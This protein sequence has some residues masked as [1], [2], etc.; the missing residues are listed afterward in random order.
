MFSP[1]PRVRIRNTC[2]RSS[3]RAFSVRGSQ[4]SSLRSGGGVAK[5]CAAA[6]S[7]PR[8]RRFIDCDSLEP[9]PMRGDRH[10]DYGDLWTSVSLRCRYACG[11]NT[12]SR[13]TASTRCGESR[14]NAD[15]RRAGQAL[16]PAPGQPSLWD[17]G[18]TC[19]FLL[20]EDVARADA[21]L[22]RA[23][24]GGHDRAEL[25]DCHGP[26]VCVESSTSRTLRPRFS[27]LIGFCRKARPGSRAPW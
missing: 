7:T 16:C 3:S 13:Q 15:L 23:K 25:A 6:P 26:Y 27:G 12:C 18:R 19:G 9:A 22:Y 1:E 8:T 2:E 5:R 4:S 21:A 11:S 14:D 10:F 24:N 20:V 17:V